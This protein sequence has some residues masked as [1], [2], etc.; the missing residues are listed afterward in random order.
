M[1]LPRS[2]RVFSFRVKREQRLSEAI[3]ENCSIS[4][5]ASRK[6]IDE[7]LCCLN[8]R[9]ELLHS[10]TVNP[11]DL[12]EG[13]IPAMLFEKPQ[14]K[15]IYEDDFLIA[16][17]KPPFI[18]S[19]RDF[20]DVESLM[21]KRFK[22][23]FAVHR[24]DRQTTGVL[25]LSRDR[26][27][28]ELMKNLFRRRSVK[29]VYRVLVYG[30]I[31]RTLRIRGKVDGRDAVTNVEPIES[32]GF[33]TYVSVR[34]ETGR[35]HQIRKHLSGA[36]HY[37]IGEFRYYRKA[38]EPRILRFSPRILLH[39]SLLEF[40]HPV[41]GKLVRIEAGIPG[42]FREFRLMLKSPLKEYA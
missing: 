27:T 23:A 8:G 1:K 19:N 4:K 24:L 10:K 14:V 28:L 39:S 32:Y 36:G 35:K 42:D 33:A 41:S 6:V 3:S 12:V 38:I 11:G 25:L 17:N 2:F 5:R 20:P 21:R 16:V 40:K 7:G 22:S 29:K 26:E 13:T 9:K 18:N 37:V 15:V 34:I 30:K 31:D